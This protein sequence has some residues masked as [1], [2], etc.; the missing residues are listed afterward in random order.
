MIKVLGRVL[1][2]KQGSFKGKDG[3]D[4]TYNTALVRLDGAVVR[5]ASK[6]DLSKEVDNEYDF[7]LELY[8]GNDQKPKL[9]IVA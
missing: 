8:S 3:S 6:I 2:Y 7:H 4:I 5:V 1:D 9:R